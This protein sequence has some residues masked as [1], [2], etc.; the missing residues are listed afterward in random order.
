M[1]TDKLVDKLDGN[2]TEA[3]V[4]TLGHRKTDVQ[5]KALGNTMLYTSCGEVPASKANDW[6][7]ETPTH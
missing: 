5:V 3:L 1:E 4:Y 2:P 6:S 7:I